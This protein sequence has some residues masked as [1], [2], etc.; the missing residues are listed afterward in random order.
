[1]AEG[2]Q[3]SRRF[4]EIRGKKALNPVRVMDNWGMATK[5]HEKPQKKGSHTKVSFRVL[6]C[7]SVAMA[8]IL[9]PRISAKGRRFSRAAPVV[10]H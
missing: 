9:S 8:F 1:T 6:L 3:H 7:P 5:S 2:R 10:N 4:A